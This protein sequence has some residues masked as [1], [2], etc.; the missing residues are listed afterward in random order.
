MK[1][2]EG[3]HSQLEIAT[4]VAPDLLS[5]TTVAVICVGSL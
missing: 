3:D 2:F 5:S 1:A 4:D